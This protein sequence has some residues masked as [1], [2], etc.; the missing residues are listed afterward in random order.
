M[1]GIKT[2]K[3]HDVSA[4]DITI[5]IGGNAPKVFIQSDVEKELSNEPY[6]TQTILG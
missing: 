1:K 2:H 5:L 6:L 3:I 4:S